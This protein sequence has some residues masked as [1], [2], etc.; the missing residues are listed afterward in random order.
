MSDKKIPLSQAGIAP[1]ALARPQGR[2]AYFTDT[3]ESCYMGGAAEAA[4]HKPAKRLTMLSGVRTKEFIRE[5]WPEI[6][7]AI[8]KHPITGE[9]RGLGATI[10]DL[11][12]NFGW[13]RH[14]IS[15]W[16]STIGY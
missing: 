15:A 14:Q 1:K 12:D 2:G 3:G 6:D 8:V 16:L 10:T 5:Q 9:D 11:S 7:N 13:S 4:G